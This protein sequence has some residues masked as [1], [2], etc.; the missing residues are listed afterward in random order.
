MS[1]ARSAS[2][3]GY[4]NWKIYVYKDGALSSDKNAQPPSVNG[5]LVVD[6]NKYAIKT[7]DLSEALLV[8][9]AGNVAYALNMNSV[10]KG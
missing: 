10:V 5:I 4:G 7:K 2:E 3:Y 9:P 6:G 8:V 1:D